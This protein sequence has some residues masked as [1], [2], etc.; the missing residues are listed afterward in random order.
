MY[1]IGQSL[2]WTSAPP[3][4]CHHSHATNNLVSFRHLTENGHAEIMTCL[5]IRNVSLSELRL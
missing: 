5:G 1:R 2:I 3:C 4:A